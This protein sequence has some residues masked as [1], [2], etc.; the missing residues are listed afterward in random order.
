MA[1]VCK[2]IN[3]IEKFF[4]DKLRTQLS[5]L[6]NS[7]SL[8]N[9]PKDLNTSIRI[10]L[11]FTDLNTNDNYIKNFKEEFLQ[12]IISDLKLQDNFGNKGYSECLKSNF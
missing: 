9:F 4:T 6:N 3:K 10:Y 11:N 7:K 5:K 8:L 1:L 12:K 2:K